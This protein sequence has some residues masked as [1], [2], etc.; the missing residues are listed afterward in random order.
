[1]YQ[2]YYMEPFFNHWVIK[3]NEDSNYIFGPFESEADA[4]FVMQM[5][6]SGKLQLSKGDSYGEEDSQKSHAIY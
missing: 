5:F 3:D 6:N 1:M 2:R 4:H